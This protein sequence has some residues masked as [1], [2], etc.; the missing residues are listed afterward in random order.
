MQSLYSAPAVIV[1]VLF[2]E[3]YGVSMHVH[4]QSL[5]PVQ[6][7]V[8]PWTVAHQ[9]CLSMEFFRQQYRIGLPFLLQ[10]ELYR[11][12]LVKYM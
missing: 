4:A 7:F 1:S 9:A 8:T 12:S 11:L 6:L 10:G 2:L 3:L 5:S